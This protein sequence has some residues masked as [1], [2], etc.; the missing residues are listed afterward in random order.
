MGLMGPHRG[1]MRDSLKKIAPHGPKSFVCPK[2]HYGYHFYPRIHG[3]FPTK[4]PFWSKNGPKEADFDLEIFRVSTCSF[5]ATF[6]ALKGS[7]AFNIT[8][9]ISPNVELMGTLL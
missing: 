7:Y 6:W 4:R 8:P 9:L 5:S 1:L 2:K 3:V